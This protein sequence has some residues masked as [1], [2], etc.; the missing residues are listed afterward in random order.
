VAFTVLVWASAFPL[1]R[2]A[3]RELA[4]LPLAA[5]RFALAG[6]LFVAW[7]GWARPRGPSL[8]DSARFVI[9]GLVGIA[10]YNGLL[11]A[12]E[13]TVSAGAAAFII[14]AVPILTAIL[15]AAFLRERITAFGLVAMLIS[16]VG[17][18]LI[19][20]DQPGG[21]SFETGATMVLGA[22]ACQATYFVLLR[23][24]VARYGPLQCTAYTFLAGAL[25]LSPW[26]ADGAA[27]LASTSVS[28]ATIVAVVV[29]GVFPGALGF[30]TWSYV[31]GHFGAVRATNFLYLVPP[32]ATCL[33][34]VL[35]GEFPGMRTLFGG[36]I[37][38]AG[39]ILF[40]ARGRH[41]RTELERLVRSPS[42]GASLAQLSRWSRP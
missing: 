3:V 26:L 28:R 20:L 15:A 33:A 14:N 27:V 29:L 6:A 24:L 30:V 41:E 17:V 35:A 12:G 34:V 8:A 4:P 42:I 13:Q 38:V 1:I 21:L 25:F 10:F 11:N 18:A 39:V 40:N 31:L 36:A 16:S 23:P 19:A 37:A 22:A 7:L 32:L 5:V 9:C 2:V